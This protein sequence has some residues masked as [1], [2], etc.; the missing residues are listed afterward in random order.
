MESSFSASCAHCMLLTVCV[1]WGVCEPRWVVAGFSP[2]NANV[3]L[4]CIIGCISQVAVPLHPMCHCLMQLVLYA[5]RLQQL[6]CAEHAPQHRREHLC[7][8]GDFICGRLCRA[9]G[10]R[11][12][13]VLLRFNPRFRGTLAQCAVPCCSYRVRQALSVQQTNGG[14]GQGMHLHA[15]STC[16]PVADRVATTFASLHP[17][18]RA[19]VAATAVGR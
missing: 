11:R 4:L 19:Y 16:I 15:A 13:T 8:L 5:F 1:S 18:L 3:S 6:V 17:T 12:L 10:C 7:M 9:H 14:R 2:R